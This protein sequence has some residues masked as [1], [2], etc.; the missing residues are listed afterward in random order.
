MGVMVSRGWRDRATRLLL[1][2]TYVK[3]S[4]LYGAAVWGSHVLPPSCSLLEDRTGK[5][6]TTYRGALRALL[7]VGR[8]R[9]EVVYVLS[10]RFPL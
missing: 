8:I 4:L 1:Y 3:S 6:G 7:G 5:L 2:D 9:N 10:G